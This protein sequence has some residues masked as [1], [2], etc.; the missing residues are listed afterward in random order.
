MAGLLL[1]ED[2]CPDQ[3]DIPHFDGPHITLPQYGPPADYQQHHLPNDFIPQLPNTGYLNA[4]QYRCHQGPWA[5]YHP[6]PY[7]APP[8]PYAAPPLQVINTQYDPYHQQQNQQAP[9]PNVATQPL[10]VSA[11]NCPNRKVWP[12]SMCPP[13][14]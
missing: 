12:G 10:P 6:P 7:A 5:H 11:C 9:G 3:Q 13:F 1:G 8:P 14:L 2:W 4:L